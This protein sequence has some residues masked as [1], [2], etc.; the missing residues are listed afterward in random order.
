[1]YSFFKV[2]KMFFTC[3]IWVLVT[4][5]MSAV[6]VTCQSQLHTAICSSLR[7]SLR[8]FYSGYIDFFKLTT[9][10]RISPWACGSIKIFQLILEPRTRVAVVWHLCT[11]IVILMIL[12]CSL[13]FSKDQSHGWHRKDLFSVHLKFFAELL[14]KYS[15]SFLLK[16]IV[17]TLRVT[18][19]GVIWRSPRLPMQSFYPC[20]CIFE[21]L[22][23]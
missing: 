10:K 21:Q 3:V 8:W 14:V 13:N 2:V 7:S 22:G 9:Y 6:G 4:Q 20:C 12:A 19:G 18:G 1:M 15:S 16:T 5:H 17:T 11:W 23:R